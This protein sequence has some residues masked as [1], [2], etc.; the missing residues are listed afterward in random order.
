MFMHA[1][2]P[3]RA[4]KR[5]IATGVA[6]TAFAAALNAGVPA[7]SIAAPLAGPHLRTA[8]RFAAAAP[9]PPR[10]YRA[11]P[12]SAFAATAGA[13]FRATFD[14]QTFSTLTHTP[15]QYPI[16]LAIDSKGDLYI[17]NHY[18]SAGQIL[19]YTESGQQ[20]PSRTITKRLTN[21]AGLAIDEAGDLYEADASTQKVNVFS[22]KGAPLPAKS[23]AVNNPQGQYALSGI[24]LDSAGNVWVALRDNS[25]IG[26]GL[27]EIYD[28]A[29]QLKTSI[30]A[31]LVYPLGIIFGKTGDAYVANAEEPNDAMTVYS[32]AGKLLRSISTPG[33]APTY[34]SFDKQ[35]TIWVTCA[36]ENDF[37]KITT[38][39]KV[40]L[41]VT[42]G[43]D[44]PYGIAVAPNGDVWVANVSASVNEY[45]P[46]GKLVRT[47]K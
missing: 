34:D 46:A 4:G 36:L 22:P 7:A 13:G 24:Q 37:E 21:P 30:T 14:G 10:G 20:L 32:P 17:G 39:G 15:I 35:G 6:F 19:V 43:V 9:G 47:L 5:S 45:T 29:K 28:S 3:G 23:F 27:I 33:C 2:S 12:N 18:N 42:S 40:L 31:G 38:S 26:I 25:D 8:P 41:T 44:A 1:T 11:A 16:G